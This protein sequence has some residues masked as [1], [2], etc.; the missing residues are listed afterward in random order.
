MRDG[1]LSA[2]PHRAQAR[3][4][5]AFAWRV[6]CCD[7]LRVIAATTSVLSRA[8]CSNVECGG[9]CRP[10]V[11]ILG[12]P[13]GTRDQAAFVGARLRAMWRYR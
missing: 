9:A 12:R 2:K 10:G 8:F 13:C 6:T 4:Y 7:R 5:V 11:M 1:A 3:A